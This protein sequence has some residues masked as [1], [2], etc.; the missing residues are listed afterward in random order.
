[1]S[2]PR[3]VEKDV[4]KYEKRR[5][6]QN[7]RDMQFKDA[8]RRERHICYTWKQVDAAIQRHLVEADEAHK[9]GGK[10]ALILDVEE[11]LERPHS[12]T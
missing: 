4:Q 12:Y 9:M 1:M 2:V 8:G 3:W 10:Y 6:E 7:R 11:P 5:Q